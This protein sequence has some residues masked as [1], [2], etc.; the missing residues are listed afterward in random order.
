MAVG[1]VGGI[2]GVQGV[3]GLQN[4]AELYRRQVAAD[5]ASGG[6]AGV[7]GTTGGT[8]AGTAAGVSA[9]GVQ[10]SPSAAARGADFAGA[11]GQSLSNLEKLDRT[12]S[13]LA[14]Q[15]ATGDLNDIHDYVITATQAQLATQL[16]TT[17][18]NK[19]ID[20]FNEIMR[21]PL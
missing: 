9:P 6:P 16:T 19:A 8:A 12:T 21:M 18:R 20:A 17:V 13:S 7:A 2:G 10:T 14:V 11:V 4:L 1:G 3:A 5:A 15:A